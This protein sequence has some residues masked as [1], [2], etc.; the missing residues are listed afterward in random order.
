MLP[1]ETI[2]ETC[3]MVKT[4]E[5][6]GTRPD[7]IAICTTWNIY[8]ESGWRGLKNAAGRLYA[9]H[10]TYDSETR[11]RLLWLHGIFTSYVFCEINEGSKTI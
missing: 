8:P 1:I 9:Q 10:L 2:K 7:L 5:K 6:S 4:A 3:T 11:R